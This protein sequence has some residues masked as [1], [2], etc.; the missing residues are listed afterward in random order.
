LNKAEADAF[1]DDMT[2][3]FEFAIAPGLITG[4]PSLACSLFS[5]DWSDKHGVT[6]DGNSATQGTIGFYTDGVRVRFDYVIAIESAG[7]LPT[8]P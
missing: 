6:Y 3:D 2:L 8:D 4:Q 1:S 7:I 5:S